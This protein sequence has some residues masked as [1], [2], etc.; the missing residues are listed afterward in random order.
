MKFKFKLKPWL[1]V[2]GYGFKL[3]WYGQA[4]LE[5]RERIT[6]ALDRYK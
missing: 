3:L 1:G 5:K 2:I 4:Y 6:R